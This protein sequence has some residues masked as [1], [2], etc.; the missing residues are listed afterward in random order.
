MTTIQDASLAGA[1]NALQ[2][3]VNPD[4]DIGTIASKVHGPPPLPPGGDA[5]DA[6]KQLEDQL[7]DRGDGRSTFIGLTPP[8]ELRIGGGDDGFAPGPCF[9]PYEPPPLIT[10]CF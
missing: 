9:P 10:D 1:T 2:T 6:W 3:A 7:N 4:P 8:G 5:W